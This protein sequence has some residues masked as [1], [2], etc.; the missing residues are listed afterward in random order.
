[1]PTDQWRVNDEKALAIVSMRLS[2][3]VVTI[4]G[5]KPD[6]DL[7]EAKEMLRREYERMQEREVSE[8][9]LRVGR[10]GRGEFSHS[11]SSQG[12]GKG[13]SSFQK[14]KQSDGGK[15][16]GKCYRYNKFGHKEADGNMAH[17]GEH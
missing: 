16:R 15:S 1:M 2:L 10:P 3:P 17:D 6:V 11:L 5:N 8:T 13:K 14:K 7:L 9:A 12:K 4:I